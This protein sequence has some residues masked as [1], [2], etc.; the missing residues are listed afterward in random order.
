MKLDESLIGLDESYFRSIEGSVEAIVVK[1][2]RRVYRA[3]SISL[4]LIE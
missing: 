4:K 1:V 3:M 2:G